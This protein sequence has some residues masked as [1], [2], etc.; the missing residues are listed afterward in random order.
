MHL[1]SLDADAPPAPALASM[2]TIQYTSDFVDTAQ[3]TEI[4]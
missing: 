2:S 1:T 3:I 4:I